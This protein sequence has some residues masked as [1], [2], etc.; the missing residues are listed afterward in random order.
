[1]LKQKVAKNVAIYL[2]HFIFTK[3]QNQLPKADNRLKIAQ[4]GHP[5]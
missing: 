1:V 4:S 3:N 5:G 2:G